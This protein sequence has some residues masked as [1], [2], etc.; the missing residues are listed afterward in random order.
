MV[1]VREDDL[2]L[3]KGVTIFA[4]QA[5]LFNVRQVIP[6]CGQIF[7]QGVFIGGSV[8]DLI[9]PYRFIR[10]AIMPLKVLPHE[11]CQAGMEEL[12][13][14]SQ[15]LVDIPELGIIGL[16]VPIPGYQALLPG[17]IDSILEITVQSRFDKLE[18][19]AADTTMEAMETLSIRPNIEAAP[20]L[21]S[22]FGRAIAA[23]QPGTALVLG[24][25]IKGL[26]HLDN[27]RLD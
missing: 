2:S 1:P 27:V 6:F 14:F 10:Q 17:P 19:I 16:I 12:G 18:S 4:Q 3:K 20:T 13:G 15:D 5:G 25:A 22:M 23:I 21:T 24:K 11:I 9:L 26:G 7:F 8:A